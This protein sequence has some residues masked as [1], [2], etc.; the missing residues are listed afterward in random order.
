MPSDGPTELLG[1]ER[2]KGGIIV[3]VLR[4]LPA[5]SS[6]SGGGCAPGPEERGSGLIQVLWSQFSNRGSNGSSREGYGRFCHQNSG[7]VA[8]PSISGVYPHPEGTIATL[9]KTVVFMISN[10]WCLYLA[11]G[12]VMYIN[13]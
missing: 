12:V 13:C 6:K 7:K 5:D 9:F 3:H 10:C 2:P 11:I 4:W 1:G 8:E